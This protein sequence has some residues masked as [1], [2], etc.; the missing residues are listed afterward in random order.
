[1]TSGA[2]GRTSPRPQS[3]SFSIVLELVAPTV[4]VTAQQKQ[5]LFAL[6][7][8][9]TTVLH[10]PPQGRLRRSA[11]WN[12]VLRVLLSPA[13]N[14][15]QKT[16]HDPIHLP[17]RPT[18]SEPSPRTRRSIRKLPS[19]SLGYCYTTRIE[20]LSAAR[21]NATPRS[22]RQPE[23]CRDPCDA[24]SFLRK[25]T[26]LPTHI[27]RPR[28]T[29]ALDIRPSNDPARS[30]AAITP[31]F[32]ARDLLLAGASD[33]SIAD[34][35][36]PIAYFAALATAFFRLTPRH[37]LPVTSPPGRLKRIQASRTPNTSK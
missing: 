28:Y 16:P 14:R 12:K 24:L 17:Q 9:H 22:A 15:L 6:L 19:L 32:R 11:W 34:T 1:V 21:V 30:V 27:R 23:P 36:L 10:T 25:T 5:A 26:T 29:P 33:E 8:S 20:A 3:D 7:G 18:E 2:I 31:R 4:V 35:R 13:I 37:H